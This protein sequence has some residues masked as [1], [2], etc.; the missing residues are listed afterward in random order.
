MPLPYVPSLVA[1]DC[2]PDKVTQHGGEITGIF[3]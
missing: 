2:V 1:E 3:I